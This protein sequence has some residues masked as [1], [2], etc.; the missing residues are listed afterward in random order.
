MHLMICHSPSSI[1]PPTELDEILS[2]G[3]AEP[4]KKL[5]G[6]GHLCGART[7]FVGSKT[8]ESGRA[9]I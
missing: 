3:R 2:G 6:I 8:I 1:A 9:E 7:T 4:T 5:F